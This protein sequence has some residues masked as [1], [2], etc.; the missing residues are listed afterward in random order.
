VPA[1][2][3]RKILLVGWD[4]ADWKF[5]SPMLDAGQLPCLAMLVERGT[6]GRLTATL[7]I[8]SPLLWTSIVTG[9]RADGHNIL[10]AVEPTPDGGRSR[11]VSRMSRTCKALWNILTQAGLRSHVVNWV[12]T[13]PAEPIAGACV[14]DRFAELADLR[15]DAWPLAPGSVHPARMEEALAAMRIHPADLDG[16]HLL[17]LVPGLAGV[18]QTVDRRLEVLA[19]HLAKA[20]SDHAAATYLLKHEP[21]EFLAVRYDA[22]D[23]LAHQFLPFRPPRSGHVSETDFAL[24]QHVMAGVYRFH[25]MML[26]RLVQLAGPEATVIVVSDH[27]FAPDYLRTPAYDQA[28]PGSIVSGHRANGFIAM[29]GPHVK[30]DELI[31]GATVLD[32]AP[33]VLTLLSLPVGEDMEGRPLLEALDD[34]SIPPRIPSW[35]SVPADAGQRARESRENDSDVS[36]MI[37]RLA[38]L[39]Y[40]E[41]T[42]EDRKRRAGIV[43]QRELN[44]AYT[45]LAANRPAAAAPL[46]EK[47]FAEEPDDVI[48]A[49]QLANCYLLLGQYERCQYVV[50]EILARRPDHPSAALIRGT[51]ELAAGRPE[52]AMAAFLNAEENK[53]QR[54]GLEIFIGQCYLRLGRGKE[55]E[56]SFRAVVARDE[57]FAPAHHGLALSLLLQRRHEEA[58]EEALATVGLNHQV[59]QAH[60]TLGL[61]LNGMGR[62]ERAVQAFETCLALDPSDIEARNWL[63]RL[64]ASQAELASRERDS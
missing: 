39:G 6:A 30:R 12:A 14:S 37:E 9:R 47:L 15:G 63:D 56:R 17:P 23:P 4:T 50:N 27:G 24:Y 52:A 58:A 21:C 49:I 44:L 33:T 38:A 28:R 5:V 25:D 29:S 19:T 64:R 46:F 13:H 16:D 35:E 48:P 1:P 8:L 32:V 22:F 20:A 10:V 54:P 57:D 40:L 62:V 36:E 7:P 59:A 42:D 41:E 53:G 45:Q 34:V 55:A 31:H 51:L 43:R 11:P 2:L 61:A 3:A 60:R 18:D 26:A